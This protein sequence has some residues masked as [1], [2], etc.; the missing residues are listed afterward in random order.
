MGRHCE[1]HGDEAIHTATLTSDMDRFATLAMTAGSL[2][3]DRLP[4]KGG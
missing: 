3:H 2:W 4:R 1:E